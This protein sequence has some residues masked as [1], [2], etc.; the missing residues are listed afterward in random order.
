MTDAPPRTDKDT[1]L[2]VRGEPSDEK[3]MASKPRIVLIGV[4]HVFDIRDKVRQIILRKAPKVVALELDHDRFE[5]LMRRDE[6]PG[7]TPFLYQLLARFQKDLAE[8]F[9]SEVGSEMIAA[10]DAA[11]EVGA[12]LALIDMDAA[13]LF[14]TLRRSMSL[15]EKAMLLVS[16][17]LAFFTRKSTVEKEMKRYTED[18]T[19]FLGEIQR[20][21]PTVMRVLIDDRNRYMAQRLREIS[22]QSDP[23][24]AVVGDGHV[25]GMRE[26]LS[27]FCDLEVFRLEDLRREDG[28]AGNR[29]LTM[30]FTLR[31]SDSK[32]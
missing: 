24:V 4:A 29:E 17:F 31:S 25:S 10:A 1:T 22:N 11:R 27:G 23:I 3:K 19:K 5:G 18:E 15:R 9:G 14:H 30:S 2:A 32:I 26:L 7:D 6:R 16:V 13:G 21:Y 28:H 8:Q 12:R 20:S